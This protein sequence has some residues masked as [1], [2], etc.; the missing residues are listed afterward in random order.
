MG[1]EDPVCHPSPENT[2]IT[3]ADSAFK[4]DARAETSESNPVPDSPKGRDEAA[5]STGNSSQELRGP[6]RKSRRIQ[7]QTKVETNISPSEI[8][9]KEETEESD[10]TPASSNSDSD[11]SGANEDNDGP[12]IELSSSRRKRGRISESYCQKNVTFKCTDCPEE[13]HATATLAEHRKSVHNKSEMFKCNICL[14]TC[15]PG[16]HLTAHNEERAPKPKKSATKTSEE[17]NIFKCIDCGVRYSSPTDLGRHRISLHAAVKNPYVCHICLY[18]CKTAGHLKPHIIRHIGTEEHKC[19]KCPKVYK[20]YM[21]LR[22]HMRRKHKITLRKVHNLPLGDPS[23]TII[24]KCKK[25]G[26]GFESQGNFLEHSRTEHGYELFPCEICQKT[27]FKKY[28]L[29]AHIKSHAKPKVKCRLC[30]KRFHTAEG[31]CKH[32][33][34]AHQE[35]GA[36]LRRSFSNLANQDPE[37]FQ[38]TECPLAFETET[39]LAAHVRCRH[40]V[41]EFKCDACEK[42]YVTKIKLRFH[43]RQMHGQLKC[44]TCHE[45][46]KQGQMAAHL[47]QAHRRPKPRPAVAIRPLQRQEDDIPYPCIDCPEISSTLKQ[48][49]THRLTHSVSAKAIYKCPFCHK[50]KPPGRFRHHLEKHSESTD[51]PCAHCS[52]RFLMRR[53]RN[54]HQTQVHGPQP[55]DDPEGRL[56]LP[57]ATTLQLISG[58][59]IHSDEERMEGRRYDM[60]F[61]CLDCDLEFKVARMLGN[62]RAVVHGCAV[63]HRFQCHYCLQFKPTAANLYQHARRHYAVE[64]DNLCELCGKGFKLPD[65]L[66]SHY[67]RIHADDPQGRERRMKQVK[68]GWKRWRMRKAAAKKAEKEDPE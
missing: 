58:E 42:S 33:K 47:N 66:K 23:E 20:S 51:W 40:K 45:I 54:A 49:R 1:N 53:H 36:E 31:R 26:V 17:D 12:T 50:D 25:C 16:F 46:I 3:E 28:L 11:D 27:F 15:R 57:P 41:H 24:I 67:K 29:N 21:S 2:N 61:K 34:Q 63:E 55:N 38:C 65:E 39:E 60:I 37:T 52:M 43:Q 62:H 4:M 68:E 22:L 44:L 19:S 48:F 9:I 10:Y 6:L 59:S 7:A 64:R 32:V 18:N 13:F 35:N 8:E 30:N 14:Q 56:P 5:N